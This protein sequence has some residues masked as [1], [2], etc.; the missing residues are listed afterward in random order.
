M[1]W[2]SNDYVVH[3]NKPDWGVGK[4]TFANSVE[5]TVF[6]VNSGRKVFAQNISLLEQASDHLC[7]HPL[8]N[9]VAPAAV[10]GTAKFFPLPDCVQYFLKLFPKGF[11]DPLYASNSA[12]I[13][14]R[15][16]KEDAR[17]LAKKLLYRKDWDVFAST[18]NYSEICQRL[19]KIESKTNLLHSFEKIK[20]HSALKNTQLQKLIC[21]SLYEEL[22]GAGTRQARFDTWSSTLG[23]CE[24][25]AKWTIAT[26]YGFLLHSEERIFIK[27][28]VTKFAAEACGWDLQYDSNLNWN[29]LEKAEALAKYLLDEL[30]R[31]GLNPRDMIDVQSFIW[32]ID[33]KSY[34]EV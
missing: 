7:N 21:D 19:G 23:N 9:N 17:D 4:V 3:K 8:L 11:E 16:Y 25:C 18:G 6:F 26:Y 32:C 2:K 12:T 14:E 5:L 1:S 13:G 22:Y 31:I 30:S 24:G 10:D 29:T 33:P 20:W 34:A 28:E 15:R 27:P